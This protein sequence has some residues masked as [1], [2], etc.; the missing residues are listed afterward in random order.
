MLNNKFEISNHILELVKFELSAKHNLIY[1]HN[2]YG[3][4]T[5]SRLFHSLGKGNDLKHELY[6]KDLTFINIFSDDG[7]NK[8]LKDQVIVFNRDFVEDI[9]GIASKMEKIDGIVEA[10]TITVAENAKE[11]VLKKEKLADANIAI[12]KLQIEI[13]KKKRNIEDVYT[14]IGKTVC[15][16]LSITGQSF[17]KPQVIKILENRETNYSKEEIKR[18]ED[19]L[20]QKEIKPLMFSCMLPD[21]NLLE[22]NINIKLREPIIKQETRKLFEKETEN[23]IKEGLKLHEVKEE[24]QFCK[25]PIPYSRILELKNFFENKANKLKEEL[26]KD[27]ESLR[28]AVQNIKNSLNNIKG[29]KISNDH[30]L[31]E[32]V[33]D[34]IMELQKQSYNNTLNTIKTNYEVFKLSIQ[35]INETID[36]KL[37]EEEIIQDINYMFSYTNLHNTV[38]ELQKITEENNKAID[39][40]QKNK[41]IAQDFLK[42]PY[43]FEE[44]EAKKSLIQSINQEIRGLLDDYNGK[45]NFSFAKIDTFH[46]NIFM[47][48]KTNIEG[49]VIKISK[50]LSRAE[51]DVKVLNENL[52]MLFGNANFRFQKNRS[53]PAEYILERNGEA[54]KEITK[55]LSEGE[56]T[57]IAISY[58]LAHCKSHIQKKMKVYIIFDDPISS[59]DENIIYNAYS[60]ISK[61]IV[62]NEQWIEKSLILTHN[63]QFAYYLSCYQKEPKHPR[64]FPEVCKMEKTTTGK[65]H[66]IKCQNKSNIN[67][68]EN[69]YCYNFKKLSEYSEKIS[70]TQDELYT[71]ANIGRKV[72]EGFCRFRTGEIH[73]TSL[74]EYI[75]PMIELYK[76]T[77][78]RFIND[79]SHL[80]QNNFSVSEVQ[81][82]N[83]VKAILEIIKAYDIKHYAIM[84]N[85]K[86]CELT[87]KAS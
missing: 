24:C 32:N 39:Y 74:N 19:S 8:A 56:K 5:I 84:S 55:Y 13:Q 34:N 50:E 1:G 85:M 11:F 86:Y 73:V 45:T 36:K 48:I 43:T 2:G 6:A 53:N 57:A 60:V 12:A 49:E 87:Q 30:L 37:Q 69:E 33:E 47:D 42:T 18:H 59:L 77:V 4:T 7:K 72:I 65:T 61:F 81:S 17:Q 25:N 46:E 58:F 68:F 40:I 78:N 23:W 67:P 10:E 79:G 62:D 9:I 14:D 27:K 82:T 71:I 66:L 35:S 21:I 44:Y 54:I 3:K 51:E 22:N 38:A 83:V 41:Q 75:N 29:I 15:K 31:I 70:V 63:H 64:L 16:R 80:L 52:K 26:Q 76:N 20:K 28:L